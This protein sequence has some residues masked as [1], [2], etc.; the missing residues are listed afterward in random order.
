VLLL[1]GTELDLDI[2]TL[3]SD[4]HIIVLRALQ[5]LNYVFLGSVVEHANQQLIA[6][7][8]Y[9]L[10]QIRKRVLLPVR[11]DLQMIKYVSR[12]PTSTYLLEC[13]IE[14]PDQGIHLD[15]ILSLDCVQVFPL[16][17]RVHFLLFLFFLV[18]LLIFVV[19]FREAVILVA[20]N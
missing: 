19:L 16:K 1:R 8:D 11:G 10:A 13:L 2:F 3:Y 4:I 14:L 20:V 6:S 7:L 15:I 12:R 9:D 5:C 18:L 17:L